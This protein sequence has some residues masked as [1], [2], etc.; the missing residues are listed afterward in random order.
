MTAFDV[1]IATLGAA[2]LSGFVPIVNIEAYLVGAA[3]LLPGCPPL[4]VVAAA[5]LGQMA[6]KTVLFLGGRG[7][8]GLPAGQGARAGGSV[9]VGNEREQLLRRERDLHRM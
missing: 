8:V 6:A 5:A 7:L 9:R 3:A 2:F 4:V 1:W